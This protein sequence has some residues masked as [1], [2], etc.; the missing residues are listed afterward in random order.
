MTR[1]R[2]CQCLKSRHHLKFEIL[3][4]FCSFFPVG[5]VLACPGRNLAPN[6]GEN[7]PEEKKKNRKSTRKTDIK[8]KGRIHI[9]ASLLCCLDAFMIADVATGGWGGVGLARCFT[10][11][12]GP[13]RCT[14]ALF[15]IDK[16]RECKVYYVSVLSGSPF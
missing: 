2:V 14:S 10:I 8:G 11:L 9:E 7:V 3:L 16:F 1:K 13:V 15:L 5:M 6:N 12:M 4:F